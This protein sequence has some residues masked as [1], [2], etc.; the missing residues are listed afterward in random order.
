MIQIVQ[1][2]GFS[3]WPVPSAHGSHLYIQILEHNARTCHLRLQSIRHRVEVVLVPEILGLTQPLLNVT[4]GKSD[5]KVTSEVNAESQHLDFVVQLLV[6]PFDGL[7]FAL[8]EVLD[9]VIVSPNMSE[10][11]LIF[12]PTNEVGTLST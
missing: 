12:S 5:A 10:M 2:H 6:I 9:D 3:S 1:I 11:T 8:L 7:G 4:D